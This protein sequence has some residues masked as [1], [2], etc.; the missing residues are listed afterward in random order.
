MSF[1]TQRG[2]IPIDPVIFAAIGHRLIAPKKLKL[3]MPTRAGHGLNHDFVF[4]SEYA[5]NSPEYD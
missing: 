2:R 3:K 1:K 4:V 5:D